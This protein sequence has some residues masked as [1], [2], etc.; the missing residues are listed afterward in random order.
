M[1]LGEGPGGAGNLFGQIAGDLEQAANVY[2]AV[3]ALR[4]LRYSGRPHPHLAA[5]VH[6]QALVAYFR[7]VLLGQTGELADTFRFAAEAMEQRRK[8]AS[9]L[10]GP[11]SEAVLRNGDMQ[12][13]VDFIMKAA[14]VTILDRR[15]NMEDGTAA[16]TRICDEAGEEWSGHSAR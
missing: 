13:S 8:V 1:R 15:G 16:I 9:G 6:G 12:K 2:A 11:G 3:R 5:C 7:A 4:E 10:A 14:A